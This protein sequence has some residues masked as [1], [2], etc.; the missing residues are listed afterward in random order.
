M[1]EMDAFHSMM[2]GKM[3]IGKLLGI[4]SQ[5]EDTL[6]DISNELVEMAIDQKRRW[7]EMAQR[8]ITVET[9]QLY[10][11]LPKVEKNRPGKNSG[12]KIAEPSFRD[13]LILLA[14]RSNM[15]VSTFYRYHKAGKFYLEQHDKLIVPLEN[16]ILNKP[17]ISCQSAIFSENKTEEEKR[18]DQLSQ[19]N[20]SRL[21][22]VSVAVDT[23]DTLEKLNRHAPE[24]I[25]HDITFR[26]LNGDT[27]TTDDGV[28]IT[29]PSHSEVDRLWKIY[30]PE[31]KPKK[32]SSGSSKP[33]EQAIKT[34]SAT[35]LLLKEAHSF[36]SRYY[37]NTAIQVVAYREVATY[38]GGMLERKRRI[39]VVACAKTSDGKRFTHGIELKT[40]DYDLMSDV[41]FFEYGGAVDCLW[42]AV[43]P[44][45]VDIARANS[46]IQ[47][48][49]G[50][51]LLCVDI[52]ESKV[53]IVFSA[54]RH[55]P[56]SRTVSS[57]WQSLFD[58][59]AFKGGK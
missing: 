40:S 29:Y 22:E 5:D 26:V 43:T 17:T 25:T 23:L 12:T 46:G 7:V 9:L 14:K 33:T 36:L 19:L 51:G 10:R 41:K 47:A 58:K 57:V 53:D 31:T 37:P 16:E 34:R 59:A 3:R 44:D 35:N 56:E 15:Q 21:N 42:L 6:E 2:S 30:R 45:I 49:G 27:K 4:V 13:W 8:T 39:D 28:E 54:E 11:F 20:I 18:F 50:I 38:T 1:S 32:A 24:S 48:Y 55:P 52:E